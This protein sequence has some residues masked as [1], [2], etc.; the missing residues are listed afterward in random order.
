MVANTFYRQVHFYCA[1]PGR[2][3]MRSRRK[4]NNAVMGMDLSEVA[5]FL[6]ANQRRGLKN[7]RKVHVWLANTFICSGGQYVNVHFLIIIIFFITFYVGTQAWFYPLTLRY[8]LYMGEGGGI[9]YLV[10]MNIS[11][12][13][14]FCGT[15]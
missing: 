10:T 6:Q 11:K 14:T 3:E 5:L 15:I 9:T 8:K 7:A 13:V 2:N 12:I 1:K 4:I